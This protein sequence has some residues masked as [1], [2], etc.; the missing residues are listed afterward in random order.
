M[1]GVLVCWMERRMRVEEEEEELE[2][3]EGGGKRRADRRR[4]H[5]RWRK[6]ERGWWRWWQALL[7]SFLKP[8]I[9]HYAESLLVSWH[10]EPSPGQMDSLFAILPPFPLIHPICSARPPYPCPVITDQYRWLLSQGPLNT[11]KLQQLSW[12]RVYYPALRDL[13]LWLLKPR[14]DGRP[15]LKPL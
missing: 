7:I 6:Q 8:G 12:V 3:V 2:E 4:R 9:S 11:M 14:E 10:P 13:S 1:L 5:R 15:P